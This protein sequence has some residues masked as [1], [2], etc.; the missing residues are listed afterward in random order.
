[1]KIFWKDCKRTICLVILAFVLCLGLE[2]IDA[3]AEGSVQYDDTNTFFFRSWIRDTVGSPKSITVRA[4]VKARKVQ[5]AGAEIYRAA[6]TADGSQGKYRKVGV[7]KNLKLARHGNWRFSYRDNTVKAGQRYIYKCKGF[8]YDGAVK[9]VQK[10]NC[11]TGTGVAEKSPE[12]NYTC[13]VI[14]NTKKKLVVKM[15]GISKK[16]LAYYPLPPATLLTWRAGWS[17]KKAGE[18]KYAGPWHQRHTAMMGKNGKKNGI[19]R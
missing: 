17:A 6:L 1:M 5:P 8:V 11:L 7:C 4:T 14:K 15:A 9:T 19:S 2:A 13:K 18:R 16:V 10:N 12:G 3:S